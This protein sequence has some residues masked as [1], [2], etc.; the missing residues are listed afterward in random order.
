MDI[1][2][3]FFSFIIIHGADF[4]S[5]SYDFSFVYTRWR[6]GVHCFLPAWLYFYLPAYLLNLLSLFLLSA[7]A[8]G[9]TNGGMA[10]SFLIFSLHTLSFRTFF[11][12]FAWI[13]LLAINHVVWPWVGISV[14]LECRE[15]LS[16]G[17]FAIF[18]SP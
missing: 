15:N 2:G 16:L 10:I 13:P 9:W 17:S 1:Q 6:F 5:F 3:Y 18:F 7:T 12:A 4:F 8:V 11:L 14:C